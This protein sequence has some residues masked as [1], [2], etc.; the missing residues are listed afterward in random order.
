M[1]YSEYPVAAAGALM[2]RVF[3]WMTV[4]LAV[5]G[6]VAYGLSLMPALQ[7]AIMANSLVFI[8]LIVAQFGLVIYLNGWIR[9]MSAGTAVVAYL[10]Y[11][12]LTGATFSA[13]FL[14]FTLP[15]LAVTFLVCA[16]MFAAMA[17]YG[18]FTKSDL[19][20]MGTYL[21]M[22]LVG[23]IIAGLI[24]MFLH[25][26]A[27]D[28]VVSL[29]GVIIFTLLTAYD[30]QMVK[31]MGMTMLGNDEEMTKVSIVCALKLYLDFVN[32]FLYLLRFFG[33]KKD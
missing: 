31:Q 8:L 12:L 7:H 5:T 25:S 15:S 16:S 10:S 3:S 32:L 29:I 13:L 23:L 22:G 14:L 19:S 30:V 2:R 4:G 6:S 1:M 33:Q 11:S 24:N 27:M 20:G 18:Y 26:S 17:L 28:F 21:L 9:S